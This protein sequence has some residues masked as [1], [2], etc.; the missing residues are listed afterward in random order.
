V[1]QRQS[2]CGVENKIM[3]TSS[4]FLGRN[5]PFISIFAICFHLQI[6]SNAIPKKILAWCRLGWADTFIFP[7][8]ENGIATIEMI[9]G[10]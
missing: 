2:F 4:N 3:S 1:G 9:E 6:S 7:S 5:F 8:W 10:N